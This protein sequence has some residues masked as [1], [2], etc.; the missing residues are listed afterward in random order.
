VN[1]NQIRILVA[2]GVCFAILVISYVPRDGATAIAEA[3]GYAAGTSPIWFP[4]FAL[5]MFLF[6]TKKYK[7][8]P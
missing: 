6:R 7:A 2:I 8:K 4:I 5:L 3:I 1:K